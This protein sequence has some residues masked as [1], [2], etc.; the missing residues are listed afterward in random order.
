[1]GVSLG[2]C[3]EVVVHHPP[4]QMSCIDERRVRMVLGQSEQ[5]F[6]Q[7]L[8]RLQ[9]CPHRMKH[10]QSPQRL[11]EFP[12]VTYLSTQLLGA[13]IG[14]FHFWGCIAPSGDQGWAQSC[15]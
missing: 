2:K 3:A 9:L 7:I 10:F 6:R 11:E 14:V 1:V 4:R 13:D 8:G 12:S 5:L 15:L